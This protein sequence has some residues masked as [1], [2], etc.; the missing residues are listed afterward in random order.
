MIYRGTIQT[1]RLLDYKS[2]GPE[3]SARALHS[4]VSRRKVH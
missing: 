2:L 4:R 3:M 1:S